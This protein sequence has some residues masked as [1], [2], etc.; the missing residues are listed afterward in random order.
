MLFSPAEICS[1][2]ASEFLEAHPAKKGWS[3]VNPVPASVEF[4][5]LLAISVLYVYSVTLQTSN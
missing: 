4:K 5:A 2:V 1:M 3:E